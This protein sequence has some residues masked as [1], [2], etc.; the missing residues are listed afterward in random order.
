VNRT[1]IIVIGSGIGSLSAACL[2]AQ[3][4]KKVKVVEQN[5]LPGGCVS[6]YWR[7]GFVFEAGATTLV[8][9]DTGQPLRYLLDAIGVQLPARKLELPMQV[10]MKT[11]RIVNRHENIE[12]WISEA[13][14][15]FGYENQAEF[16]RFCYEIAQFVWDT[17][18]KQRTFPISSWGDLLNAGLNATP[19]QLWNA[20]W[21]LYSMDYLLEKYGLKTN[22]DFVDFINA[23][24]LITAQNTMENVNVLFG[25]TA[26]CYTNFGNYYLDG[27][28]ITLS[29][30]LVTFVESKGGEIVYKE[31]VEKLSQT[32]SG[33]YLVKTSKAL[34]DAE[35]VVSGIPL[36]NTIALAD[37]SINIKHKTKVLTSNQLNSAFQMGIGFKKSKAFSSIHYQ[38]HLA[39]PLPY[40]HAKTIFISLSHPG[41]S[42]RCDNAATMVASVSTHWPDPEKAIAYDKSTI[43]N[44]VIDELIKQDFFKKED[45]LYLHSATPDAW[46]KWTKRAYG[47]VGGYPQFMNIKPW[48]M[49][50]AR[51]DGHKAYCVGDSV[52]PGQGIPGV[53]LSGIVAFE[54]M[55]RD[56]FS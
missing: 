24:L 51:L 38:I 55:K 2:L 21:S 36:N 41:D 50:D 20:R 7:K 11:G 18:L 32:A 15:E 40:I 23:Q 34:Y 37:D 31:N 43:E 17:S 29:N 9:L 8:G 13:K 4:G 54:K 12:D 45:V 28:L 35:Y 47:F 42:T 14:A 44:L 5:Y 19:L 26:L 22:R 52:Y 25:A 56:W 49:A 1:E 48:Q 33:S 3:A 16:W 39:E 6:S 27:G 10:R 30:A 46:E 53:A